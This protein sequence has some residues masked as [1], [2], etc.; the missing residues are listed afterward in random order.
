MAVNAGHHPPPPHS[1][2]VDLASHAGTSVAVTNSV[3]AQPPGHSR[4]QGWSVKTVGTASAQPHPGVM[5]DVCMHMMRKQVEQTLVVDVTVGQGLGSSA[6][7]LFSWMSWVS[8][9]GFLL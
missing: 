6:E 9:R 8:P 5:V 3:P 2:P 4:S 1:A 7:A